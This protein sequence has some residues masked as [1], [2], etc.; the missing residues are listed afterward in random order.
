MEIEGI[1]ERI[2]VAIERIGQSEG[3]QLNTARMSKMIERRWITGR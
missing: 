3:V 1:Q 2:P